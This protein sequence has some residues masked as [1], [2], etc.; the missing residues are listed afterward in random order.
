[1]DAGG[2]DL[3]GATA[4]SRAL[5]GP[6]TELRRGERWRGGGKKSC[7]LALIGFEGCARAEHDTDSCSLLAIDKTLKP[8][9]QFV[10]ESV[11]LCLHDPQEE[12]RCESSR[13]REMREGKRAAKSA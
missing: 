7:F 12:R 6:A 3:R 11:S 10:A 5:C 8:G 13:W 2:S 1:M 9:D 4:R